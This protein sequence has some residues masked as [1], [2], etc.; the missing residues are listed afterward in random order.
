MDHR[1]HYIKS[2]LYLVAVLLIIGII[3]NCSRFEH[4]Q[5]ARLDSMSGNSFDYQITIRQAESELID[6]LKGISLQ[7]K[8]SSGRT[9]NGR[10]TI[11]SPV[12]K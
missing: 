12:T 8:S 3:S 5:S 11:V 1:I 7:S 9:I 6:F 2:F 4:I 10:Y